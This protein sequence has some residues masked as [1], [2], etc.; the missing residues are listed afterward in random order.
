MSLIRLGAKVLFA[1]ADLFLPTPGGPRVLIYHQVG[2]SLGRQ[3]EVTV[4]TFRHQL[5]W[6]V[7]NKQVVDLETAVERWQEPGSDRLV[8]L[9]FDDGYVDTH[10]IAY[11]MMKE[12]GIPFTLYLATEAIETG[13]A[14]GPS[15]Q[16]DPLR[17]PH[18][19]EMLGSGLVTLGSHTHRH[20]DLR[21][22]DA[23]MV[24]EELATCDQLIEA[25]TG[26]APRHFAYPW[27][28]WGREADTVVRNRYQT[29]V[30]GGSPH[31]APNPSPYLLHRYPVQLSDGVT[32]FKARVR[33][34]LLLEEAIRGRIRGYATRPD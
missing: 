13:R 17:W 22:L 1:A 6:L 29:A 20:T 12:R 23:T 34:G 7:E 30:L 19:L 2:A 14:L 26:I 3:M 10:S 28:Y 16:A 15:P 18:I 25:R 9:S 33:G 32:F 8:V 31:P 5:N 27:G 4:D 21:G 11:P 24:E